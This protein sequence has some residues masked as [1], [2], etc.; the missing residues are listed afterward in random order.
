MASFLSV[1]CTIIC[2]GIIWLYV[3]NP[4]V[5]MGTIN[6]IDYQVRDL[7][8]KVAYYI[9]LYWLNIQEKHSDLVT[10]SRMTLPLCV[11]EACSLLSL[12]VYQ[13]TKEEYFTAAIIVT[14]VSGKVITF[15]II[16]DKDK[17]NFV[18]AF[19]L[20][21]STNPK[22]MIHLGLLE[23]HPS[24]F[25]RNMPFSPP[26]LLNRSPFKYLV[27]KEFLDDLDDKFSPIARHV[28]F[29]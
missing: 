24:E 6:K 15:D 17:A 27:T 3:R 21:L 4:I 13:Y 11:E 1:R 7:R 23:V 5:F 8:D 25:S 2:L 19:E 20:Y 14:D 28:E 12:I 16:L 18:K 9:G 10:F 22:P 26:Q 29:A